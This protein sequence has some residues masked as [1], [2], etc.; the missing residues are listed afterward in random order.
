MN[1]S[2]SNVIFTVPNMNHSLNI[3]FSNINFTGWR[4]QI[5]AYIKGQ[6]VYGFLDGTSRSPTQT[7]PNTSTNPGAPV[8][9]VDSEFLAWCQRDQMIVSMLISTFIESLVVHAVGSAT[10]HD[11]WT[12]LVTMFASQARSCVMQIHY[13]LA[14]SKKGNSSII[15][16]FQTI[17]AMSDNLAAAGQHL[18]A[19]PTFLLASD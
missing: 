10:A 11:L 13:Q 17:K 8:T 14:T 15:E 16:Y 6:D 9:M 4:T 2:S 19:F 1:P 5:L 18:K 7:I 12:T 3:K